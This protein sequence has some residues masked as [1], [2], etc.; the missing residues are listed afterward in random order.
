MR[1]EDDLRSAF[2]P[3]ERYTPT[4]DLTKVSQG[5]ARRRRARTGAGLAVTAVAAGAAAAIVITQLPAAGPSHQTA[6]LHPAKPTAHARSTAHATPTAHA[7]PATLTAREVLLRAATVAAGSP[8]TGIYWREEEITGTL[9]G[10]ASGPRVYAVDQ[11]YAPITG[12]D[13]RSAGQRTWTLPSTGETTVPLPGGATAAWQ[14]AGSPALPRTSSAQQAWWQV[15]G[16]VGNLGNEQ[17]TY[18]QL[19]ALPAGPAGLAKA[20]RAEIA[21]EYKQEQVPAADQDAT[22]RMFEISAVLLKEPIPAP[23][24]AAVFKVLASLPDVH[25][26]GTVTDPL[27]HS[28]YGIV[29]GGGSDGADPFARLQDTAVEVLVIDPGTGEL[30]DDEQVQTA[31]P[32]GVTPASSG[33]VPGFANCEAILAAIHVPG[34][35]CAPSG[36]KPS[37][38]TQQVMVVTTPGGDQTMV[39]LGQPLLAVPEG[40]VVSYDAV[41]TAGWTSTRPVLPPAADQFDAATQGKG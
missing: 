2:T 6:L 1:T 24:R 10:Y 35:T 31:L 14:A 41:I 12:W 9:L 5:A 15:G 36:V 28:G 26:I 20:M 17:L 16:N 27:G 33:A 38:G 3:Q 34:T 25:T 30:V 19:Q 22:F 21:Q 37:Y 18:T 4:V 8:S 32:A 11:R 7:V 23:V 29:L 39:Q 40:T 13:S